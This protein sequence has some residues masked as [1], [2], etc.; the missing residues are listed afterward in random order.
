MSFRQFHYNNST[1]TGIFFLCGT[2]PLRKVILAFDLWFMGNLVRI[3]CRSI[4]SDQI[5]VFTLSRSFTRK[6]SLVWFAGQRSQWHSSAVDGTLGRREIQRYNMSGP[7]QYAG[8]FCCTG[9]EASTHSKSKHSLHQLRLRRYFREQERALQDNR[10]SQS[11][12]RSAR[13]I[14]H[15]S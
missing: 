4:P 1:V 8:A 13:Q 6:R 7:W 15:S 14:S 11:G 10:W 5:R 3:T 2:S 12:I 9:C